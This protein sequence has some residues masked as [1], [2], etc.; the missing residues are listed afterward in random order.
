MLDLDIQGPLGGTILAKL[1]S[2]DS[3]G[4]KKA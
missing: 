4:E 2:L 3:H 1:T